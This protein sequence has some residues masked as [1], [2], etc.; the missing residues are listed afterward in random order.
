MRRISL[1]L[2]GAG[3]RP[4]ASK[5]FCASGSATIF[6]ISALSLAILSSGV[7]RGANIASHDMALKLATPASRSVGIFGI[8]RERTG[9]ATPKATTWPLPIIGRTA[10]RVR[11]AQRDLA[12]RDRRRRRRAAAI[13]HGL[14]RQPKL[15]LEQF[16]REIGRRAETGNAVAQR[17]GFRRRDK[18]GNRSDSRVGIG[19]QDQRAAHHLADRHQDR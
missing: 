8:A 11:Q 6:E 13:G 15:T 16:G 2:L 5:T 3:S 4:A 14:H 12:G 19:G 17:F 7:P 9:S 1:G 10:R 18:I